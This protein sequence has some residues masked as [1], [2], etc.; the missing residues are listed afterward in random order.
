MGQE[1]PVH[2]KLLTVAARNILRPMGL[3]Q[4]GRSRTWLD[5]HQWW[6]CVVEFQPSSWSRG[7]YL[8]V[9]CMWLWVVKDYISF[10][11]G[12]RVEGFHDFQ[13]EQ[14]FGTEAMCLAARA[15]QEVT[16]YRALFPTVRDVAD[17]YQR[18]SPEVGWPSYHAAIACALSHRVDEARRLFHRFTYPADTLNEFVAAAQAEAEQLS[19]LAGDAGQ[20]E[21][22][23]SEKVQRS[24]QLQRLPTIPEFNFGTAA[25]PAP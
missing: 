11:E 8:N 15:A 4:K 20:F 5:D 18:H 21:R 10:D 22:V 7:S 19:E 2:S 17:Y 16:R 24:R 3:V 13:D 6:M 23:I 1:A 25:R 9:G 12:Y 14:Q